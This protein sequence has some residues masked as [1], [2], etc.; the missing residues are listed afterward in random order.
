MVSTT[1][2]SL[3]AAALAMVAAAAIS[4]AVAHAEDEACLPGQTI[5]C[6]AATNFSLAA[7]AVGDTPTK[8]LF[9]NDFIWIQAVGINQAFA[10]DPGTAL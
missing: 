3:G 4:P 8:P 5:E 6:V 7:L 2:V 10:T 1:K 9:Q